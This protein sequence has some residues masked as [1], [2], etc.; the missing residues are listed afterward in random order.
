MLPTVLSDRT[1]EVELSD[2][3]SFLKEQ[4]LANHCSVY[5]PTLI[6][7][8]QPGSFLFQKLI[9]QSGEETEYVD[10]IRSAIYV[11]DAARTILLNERNLESFHLLSADKDSWKKSLGLLKKGETERGERQTLIDIIPKR[12][13]QVCVKPSLSFEDVMELQKKS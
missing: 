5:L 9:F 13:N 12:S 2:F 4:S 1:G 7:P 11:K 3:L 10:D 6:G 8:K